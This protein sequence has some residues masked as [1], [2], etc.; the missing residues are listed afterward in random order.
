MKLDSKTVAALVLPEGKR[1]V[2]FWDEDLAGYG[3]R[4][5]AGG[6]RVF[7]VQYR[8]TGSRKVRRTTPGAKLTEIEA[9]REARRILSL[10]TLG[11]DPQGERARQRQQEERT[12]RSAIESYLT[13]KRPELRPTSYRI[14]RGYLLGSYFKPLHSTAVDKITRADIAAR[15]AAITRKH[16]PYTA[17]AVRRHAQAAFRTFMAD[18]WIET[19]PVIGTRKAPDPRA[20]DFVLRDDEIVAVWNACED[21]DFGRIVRLLLLLGSRRQEVGGMRWS[22]LRDLDGPAPTWELPAARSKNKKTHEISLP[23]AAVNIIRAI[24]HANRDHLFGARGNRGFSS[25]EY[26][27]ARFDRRLAGKVRPGWRLHD[28][29]RTVASK[30]GDIGIEPWHVEAVLNHFSGHRA[31]TAGVYQRSPYARQIRDA[32]LR[33]SDYLFALIEGSDRKVIPMT[34]A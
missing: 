5:R 4:I 16:G 28:A 7:V 30:M 18:G 9:R 27:K 25:W 33:W 1:D 34:R 31:G 23:P 12:L 22:E 11:A 26:A 21:D 32:L 13:S 10:V 17:A 15:L 14:C 3:Y 6:K 20:R 2:T 19:N 29:R 24:P 8:P